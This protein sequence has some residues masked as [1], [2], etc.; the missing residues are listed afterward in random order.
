MPGP[1]PAAPWSRG[2]RQR[3]HRIT[4]RDSLL[5]RAE[6]PAQHRLCATEAGACKAVPEMWTDTGPEAHV[7]LCDPTGPQS[8]TGR[9]AH[10]MAVQGSD[11]VIG[12]GTHAHMGRGHTVQRG[13]AVGRPVGR[14]KLI[15]FSGKRR[16]S[17]G[18]LLMK[19]KARLLTPASCCP[20][21]PQTRF[22]W[23]G[24]VQRA[25]P[26]PPPP[27]S[28]GALGEAAGLRRAHLQRKLH[29]LTQ[30]SGPGV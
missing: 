6:C 13:V 9:P 23:R 7:A 5:D 19:R 15:L 25:A 22:T 18:A 27:H 17:R 26:P 16:R 4:A 24:F 12:N 20:S 30:H 2:G 28:S 1:H 8:L 10:A 29:V 11:A 3:C 14:P 21:A